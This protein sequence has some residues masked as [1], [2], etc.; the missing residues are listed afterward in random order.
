MANMRQPTVFKVELCICDKIFCLKDGKIASPDVVLDSHAKSTAKKPNVQCN[1]C[2]CKSHVKASCRTKATASCDAQACAKGKPPNP[3]GPEQANK[4][5]DNNNNSHAYAFATTVDSIIA[6]NMRVHAPRHL[7]NSTATAHILV[8]CANF[9]NL[10]HTPGQSISSIGGTHI[11]V[12]GCRTATL[13][14][15]FNGKHITVTLKDA[16][17][18]PNASENLIFMARLTNTTKDIRFTRNSLKIYKLN[19]QPLVKA[20]KIEHLYQLHTIPLNCTSLPTIMPLKGNN[21]PQAIPLLNETTIS[22]NIVN[23]LLQEE[24]H[25]TRTPVQHHNT[26]LSIALALEGEPLGT[27]VNQPPTHSN[28]P[29]ENDSPVPAT[30]TMHVPALTP[31]T[32]IPT[33]NHPLCITSRLDKLDVSKTTNS[34]FQQTHQLSTCNILY[35][36]IGRHSDITFSILVTLLVLHIL[37]ILDTSG[38]VLLALLVGAFIC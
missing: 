8:N 35:A 16:L 12:I 13:T 28:K 36:T 4:A 15:D 11:P 32:V 7:L 25:T 33:D 24:L 20:T 18:V 30:S 1:F 37:S 2:L 29:A 17:Y 10:C 27:S 19:G 23:T 5:F 22:L 14:F 34:Y 26:P 31:A 38:Y 6:P 3:T 9:V 21:T